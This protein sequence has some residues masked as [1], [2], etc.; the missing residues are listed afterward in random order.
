[1]LLFLVSCRKNTIG[2][3]PDITT[4]VQNN[5]K[6]KIGSA[7]ISNWLQAKIRPASPIKNNY[8]KKI[9]GNVLFDKMYVEEL[10]NNENLIIVPLKNEYF[11]QHIKNQ[12]N[13]PL[14]Y[15]ILVE[16]SNG[17]IRRGDIVLFFP[18]NAALQKL[19]NNYFHKFF[20][21]EELSVNGT[22]T[23]VSFGDVKQYEMVFKDGKKDK[24]NLWRGERNSSSNSNSTAS[25]VAEGCTDWYLVTTYYENGIPINTTWDYLG[26]TCSGS[27][28]PYTECLENE[29]VGGGG[30]NETPVAVTRNAS[31]TVKRELTSYEDWEIKPTFQLSGQTFTNTSSNYFT[32]IVKVG[33]AAGTSACLYYGFT[34]SSGWPQS[35]RYS[36]YSEISHQC[37]YQNTTASASFICKMYYPNWPASWNPPGQGPSKTDYYSKGHTWQASVALY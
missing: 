32:G 25:A 36:I 5:S 13:K 30:G 27:C 16:N 34:A 2:E 7:D 12:I 22:F 23:L 14:Q 24:F 10:H 26:T 8:I 35:A 33:T 29:G 1:M 37:A 31:Y 4:I 3:I 19:P 15:L 28:P 11:S 21:E 17:K 20:N 18:E 9:L 6:S